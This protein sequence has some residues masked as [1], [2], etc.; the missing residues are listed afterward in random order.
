LPLLLTQAAV[1][2]TPGTPLAAHLT[3]V[4]LE[5]CTSDVAA[6]LEKAALELQH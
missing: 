5:E 3:D 4:A 2:A 6:L 1:L